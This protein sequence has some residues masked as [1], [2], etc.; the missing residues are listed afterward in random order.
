MAKSD[1]LE[2]GTWSADEHSS[3]H[4]I[5][6]KETDEPSSSTET[7]QKNADEPSSTTETSRQ[8]A[9]AD[10]DANANLEKF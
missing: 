2:A 10:R 5:P 7:P 8:A 6:E 1:D 3:I 4:D 9:D